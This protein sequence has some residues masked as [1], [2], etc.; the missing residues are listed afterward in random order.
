MLG[1]LCIDEQIILD[2]NPRADL[3]QYAIDKSQCLQEDLFIEAGYQSPQ[4]H[5]KMAARSKL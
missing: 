3:A 1:G 2:N 5:V 4:L